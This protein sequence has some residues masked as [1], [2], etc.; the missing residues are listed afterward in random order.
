MKVKDDEGLMYL[1]SSLALPNISSKLDTVRTFCIHQQDVINTKLDSLK[2]TN[3]GKWILDLTHS[4]L[5]SLLGEWGQEFHQLKV[6]CDAS[7]PLQEDVEIFQ[8]MVNREEK[9]FMEVAGK[10]HPTSFNLVSLPQLV[11]S[12]SHPGIQIADILAGTFAFVYRENFKG[13]YNSYLKEWIPH[14]DRCISPYSVVPDLRHLDLEKIN[15]KRNY[16]ILEELTDRSIR[17]ATLLD[18][19]DIFLTQ[20][21]YYLYM[22]PSI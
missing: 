8:L 13:N 14:I 12:Q 3:V 18:G 16:L 4:S 17:K 2:G 22:N 15:V 1:F 6:F 21:T 11:N 9:L 5:F 10:K 7:K 19:I 20:I